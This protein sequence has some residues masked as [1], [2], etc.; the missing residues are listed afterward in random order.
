MAHSR[1]WLNNQLAQHIYLHV[2]HGSAQNFASKFLLVR[3]IR[4]CYRRQVRLHHWLWVNIILHGCHYRILGEALDVGLLPLQNDDDVMKMLDLVPTHREIEVYVEAKRRRAKRARKSKITDE[5]PVE[6]SNDPTIGPEQAEPSIDGTNAQ[7][8]VTMIAG[9]E[10]AEDETQI[11]DKVLDDTDT[12]AAQPHVSR[13]VGDTNTHVAQPPVS[14]VDGPEQD[15][16]Q[17]KITDEDLF[18]FAHPEDNV[19]VGDDLIT[20]MVAELQSE[21]VVL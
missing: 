11:I 21:H 12:I 7:S 19:G 16:Q 3:L 13:V 4:I 17:S 6:P 10:Q 8:P 18:Q 20:D 15:E 1:M 2:D 9:R 5:V 14:R